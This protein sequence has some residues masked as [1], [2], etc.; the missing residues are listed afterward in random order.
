MGASWLSPAVAGWLREVEV[1]GGRWWCWKG[2]GK[3]NERAG[4]IKDGGVLR[5]RDGEGGKKKTC[6]KAW[7]VFCPV[8]GN[9]GG[10]S[11]LRDGCFPR[12]SGRT[13]AVPDPA[14]TWRTAEPER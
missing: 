7:E 5:R 13:G 10:G 9:G 3:R 4:L 11:L 1:V 12:R 14:G 8:G 2:G 6:P